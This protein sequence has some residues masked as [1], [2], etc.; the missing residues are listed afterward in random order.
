VFVAH[1]REYCS[2]RRDPSELEAVLARLREALIAQYGQHT[3]V[4]VQ[5]REAE[6]LAR[7]WNKQT[8]RERRTANPVSSIAHELLATPAIR[9]GNKRRSSGR[10]DR[11]RHR[12]ETYGW[13]HPILAGAKERVSRI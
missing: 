13:H 1:A 11:C 6:I 8:E 7:A 4:D 12:R 5:L 10:A 9:G 2:V 3:R